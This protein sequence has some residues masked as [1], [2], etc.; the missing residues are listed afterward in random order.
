MNV[1]ILAISDSD[2]DFRPLVDEYTKR[3]GKSVQIINLK[4]IKH[5]SREQIIA[6]ETDM[7][8]ERLAKYTDSY[9]ILLSKEGKALTTEQFT[10]QINISPPITFIIGGPYGFDEKRLA[11]CIDLRLSFGAQTMPHGLVK[12]VLLE[13][14]YRASTILQHK[15][16]HY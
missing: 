13:Q 2:K 8:A 11:S 16:Y 10:K 14:I 12:V 3:L 1:T 5:G 4:P 7:L 9:R 15:S 6:K